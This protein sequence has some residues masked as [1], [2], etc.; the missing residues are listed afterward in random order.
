MGFNL[1]FN[2]LVPTIVSIKILSSFH[3][4]TF[5]NWAEIFFTAFSYDVLSPLNDDFLTAH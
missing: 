2:L 4:S 3:W 5:E 1:G